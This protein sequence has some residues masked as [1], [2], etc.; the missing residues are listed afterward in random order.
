M[1]LFRFYPTD[2]VRIYVLA[3]N[4]E[5]LSARADELFD[6]YFREHYSWVD[7]SDPEEKDYIEEKRPEFVIGL[8]GAQE[9]PAGF[10]IDSHY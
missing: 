7:M 5:Q 8:V 4:N 1:K 2:Y 10:A 6:L 9:C 3:E